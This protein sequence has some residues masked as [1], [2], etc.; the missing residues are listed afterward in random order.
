MRFPWQPREYARTCLE[1]GYT[2]RVPR[3]AARRRFGAISNFSVAGIGWSLD[4]GELGREVASIESQNEVTS[5]FRHCPKCTAGRFTQQP[6][7]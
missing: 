7:R 1:C 5:T 6:V 3:T 4:R 2:W